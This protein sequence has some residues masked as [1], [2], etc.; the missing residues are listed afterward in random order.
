MENKNSQKE[1]EKINLKINK[2]ENLLLKKFSKI[3]KI[4]HSLNRKMVSFQG[5]KNLPFYGLYKFKE[6]FSVGL[7]EHLVSRYNLESPVIDCFGG[8]GTTL[9]SCSDLGMNADG[10]ELLPIG[11]IC[12]EGGCEIRKMSNKTINSLL[13]WKSSRMWKN[14]SQLKINTL[15]ISNG[16]YPKETEID[17]G[18]FINAIKNE[19][20]ELKKILWFVLISILESISYTR[21][22]GQFLRWDNRS[23]RD[24]KGF[25][26]KGEID[27][28]ETA[29]SKKIDRII[30]DFNL[31]K[32]N[33]TKK[34]LSKK[35]N[36]HEGSCL[37]VMPRM[38]DGKYSTVITSPPYCNR[39]DYTRTYALELAL[40]DTNEENLSKMRQS[41]ITSTVENKIKPLCDF[42]KEFSI[43]IN[44]TKN[45]HLLIEILNHLEQMKND[46]KLN[47][48][49]IPRMING[50]FTE[51]SC[52]IFECWRLLKSGGKMIMVNDNVRFGGINISVDLI[53]SQIA[54]EIGFKIVEILVLPEK[55]GNSSQ[56]MG[57]FGKNEL[58]KCLYYWEKP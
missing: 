21:K 1:I 9:F 4:D 8:S 46:K 53:L 18:K 45:N 44:I 56:Q 26:N 27:S 28:F 15:R 25:F 38:D 3:T 47:N 16:A 10:I 24:L 42:K 2:Q 20:K 22:D 54:E 34:T 49:S 23:N 52:V 12:F 39:Y 31:T 6:A 35:L 36:L 32:S 57:K 14:H 30:N 11:K 55:K 37:N 29:V 40:L 33:N 13:Q 58:R 5:N 7:I 17:I 41:L 48:N 43:P 51:M 50:Y 19:N